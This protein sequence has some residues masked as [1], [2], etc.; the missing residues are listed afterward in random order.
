MLKPRKKLTKKEIKE[1]KFVKTALQTRAFIE[2][3][4]R[5]VSI[6]TGA[7]FGII[8]L[9]MVYTYFQR[10]SSEKSSAILGQAQLEYQNMNYTK[11]KQF[12]NRLLDEYSGTEAA[13]QGMFL[14]ANLFYQ[15]NNIEQAK[16]LYSEFIDSYGGSEILMA[17]GYAGYAA[18]LEKEERFEEAAEYYLK[19]SKKAPEFVE[20]PNYLYLAGKNY[21]AAELPEEAK[22]TFQ[23]IIKKYEDSDR[24]N[25]AKS[26]L[27]LLAK[28]S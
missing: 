14:L 8:I 5:Q 21:L 26:Q 28:K 2:D 6:I 11:A 27:I 3:N 12:L 16:Q 1:D 15:E 9:I 4:Y 7:V 20:A 19:A 13:D 17:S 24:F 23:T 25:D 22:D 18:C 10:Q